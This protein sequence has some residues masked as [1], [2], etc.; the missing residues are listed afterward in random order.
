MVTTLV[1]AAMV[2]GVLLGR[3]EAGGSV[4]GVLLDSLVA[5]TLWLAVY[6]R[7]RPS[8]G[9]VKEVVAK[10]FVGLSLGIWGVIAMFR[11]I[12]LRDAT[13]LAVNYG[14]LEVLGNMGGAFDNDLG[15]VLLVILAAV[16]LVASLFFL[17]QILVTMSAV[18]LG[19]L[20][21]SVLVMRLIEVGRYLAR[22]RTSTFTEKVDDAEDHLA[23]LCLHVFAKG[24]TGA[25]IMF[26]FV[27]VQVQLIWVYLGW[28]WAYDVVLRRWLWR[29]L[30]TDVKARVLA[31]VVS[32]QH[33]RQP[34]PRR[35]LARS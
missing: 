30:G 11:A 12:T 24:W 18:D 22:H 8:G 16:L 31:R 2:A 7:L 5:Y 35:Q 19:W 1:H 26:F 10:T 6:I 23:E 14:I 32:R 28:S 21:A 4:I 33:E 20:G 9:G 13:L 29:R 17:G 25:V 34:R 15:G 27:D 3:W